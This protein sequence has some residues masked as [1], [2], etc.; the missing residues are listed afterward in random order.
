MTL[1]E[2]KLRRLTGQHLL[3]PTDTQTVVKDLCGV[4]AQFLSHAL[5]CLSI[6]CN[7]VNTDDLI[8]SWTNRIHTTIPTFEYQNRSI[9]ELAR[10][11]RDLRHNSKDLL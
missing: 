6:R 10:Q 5:H 9:P 11:L 8:K 1:E 2:I 4:Q 7:E 3:T